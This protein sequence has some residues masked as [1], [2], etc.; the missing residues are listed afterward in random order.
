MSKLKVILLSLILLSMVV[1]AHGGEPNREEPNKGAP[2]KGALTRQLMRMS[3]LDEQ[4]NQIKQHVYAN[5]DESKDSLPPD[6]YEAMLQVMGEAY[7]GKKMQN[8]VSAILSRSLNPDEM[9]NILSWLQSGLGRKITGLEEAASTP[10]AFNEMQTFTRQMQ[11]NPP[12]S[13]R[14]EL[15]Q[16]LDQ[17]TNATTMAVDIILLT[18]YGVAAALDTIMPEDQQ[19]D[20]DMIRESFESQRPQLTPIMQQM[21]IAS[22]LFTYQA[23]EDAEIERYVDF[24]ESDVGKKY[25]LVVGAA[26]MNALLE[27]TEIM[28]AEL[29]N[30]LQ[31]LPGKKAT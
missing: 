19:T 26:M 27:A 28:R 6:L 4:L 3:G 7:D 18:A 12:T 14:L 23:L 29:I 10:E 8:I 20:L 16:R 30:V 9:R 25:N 22:F 21:T 11:T 31:A 17:A 1:P 5:L 13:H 15:S 2:N 24:C